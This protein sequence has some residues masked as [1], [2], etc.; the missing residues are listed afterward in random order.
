MT[1]PYRPLTSEQIERLTRLA[2]RRFAN[3]RVGA[4]GGAGGQRGDD[5]E[6]PGKGD[7]LSVPRAP[8]RDACGEG[9]A[10]SWCAAAAH[11]GL[12]VYRDRPFGQGDSVRMSTQVYILEPFL[13][14]VLSPAFEP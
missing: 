12:A 7:R 4:D 14:G 13:N 2:G 10:A 8:H 1:R 9:L 6:H 3:V 5:D 11:L